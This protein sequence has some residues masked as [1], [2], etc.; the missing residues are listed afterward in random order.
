MKIAKK[1]AIVLLVILIGM[2][3]YRPDKNMATGDYVSAF[4]TETQPG[5]EVQKV[6]ETTCYDCHS[7]NTVY[8]WYN[9][10]APISYWI[11]GHIEE[12][13]EHLDFSDWANYSAKKKDHKLEE[14]V[15]EIEEGEMP[16]KE[17]TWTHQDARLSED[18]RKALMDW[19]TKTR[20]L[21][22]IAD[23]QE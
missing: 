3:F 2:Q 6:L 17:Y 23:Q 14:L 18:Q 4:E 22:Q 9:N 12:G 11:D 13:K 15:E 8:P 10:I 21:Y 5:P 7:D 1:I 16:L 20:A 19:A